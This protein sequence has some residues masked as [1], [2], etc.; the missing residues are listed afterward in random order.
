[1]AV[2]RRR[3]RSRPVRLFLIGMLAVP[4][5]SLVGLWAF[6]TSITAISAIDNHNYN[7]TSR[8]ITSRGALLS[9]G[10]TDERAQTYLWL[11]TGQK[12][13]DNSMIASRKLVDQARNWDSSPG[14]GRQSTPER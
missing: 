11:A 10:L 3:V 9:V 14:Y 7:S 5:V 8:A 4:L 13:A 12:T 2:L 6:A 1:M